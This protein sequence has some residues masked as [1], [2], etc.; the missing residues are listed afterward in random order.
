MSS[1]GAPS[2]YPGDQKPWGATPRKTIKV[3]ENMKRFDASAFKKVGHKSSYYYPMREAF[4]TKI[5]PKGTYNTPDPISKIQM[6]A[7]GIHS[8]FPQGDIGQPFWFS[9][10]GGNHFPREGFTYRPYDTPIVPFKDQVKGYLDDEDPQMGVNFL[11]AKIVGGDHYWRGKTENL[12]KYISTY[13]QGLNLNYLA[14]QIVKELLAYGNCFVKPRKPIW[15]CTK[16]EDFLILPIESSVRIW[17]T[18]DRRPIWYEFR[19]AEYNGY[20][21][22]GELIHFVWNPANGSLYGFGIM[23]QLVNRVTYYEDTPDGPIIKIRESLLDIKHGSQNVSYKTQKRY[24]PRNVYGAF[25]TDEVTRDAMREELRVLHDSEDIVHGIKGLTIQE[26]GNQTRPIDP[27]VFMDM[28]QSSI[29]KAVQTSKGRIAGQSEG[30]SYANGEESSILDEIGLSALPYQLKF[31]LTQFII[32]P[33][34]EGNR[35]RDKDIAMGLVD[36]PFD[37][38]DFELEFGKQVKKDMEPEQ[39]AQWV[40]I[41]SQNNAI[42]PQEIRKIADQIGVPGLMN[43]DEGVIA[44]LNQMSMNMMNSPGPGNPEDNPKGQNPDSSKTPSAV[45]KQ[46]A[47][48]NKNNLH[49]RYR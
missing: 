20:F 14:W 7:G 5:M 13:T 40:Q 25:N 29:F 22:P 35:I 24:L 28:F 16:I 37:V 33:W 9:N 12:I 38:C 18:P 10:I 41:L 42:L 48:T 11:A 26:L 39:V 4:P 8:D 2:K 31:Q 45:P 44:Q 49:N 17:W 27:Q 21:R 47:T 30:P 3:T 34:Y 23:A 43:T 36:L 19:G 46:A 1:I 6:Q 32:K 15:E